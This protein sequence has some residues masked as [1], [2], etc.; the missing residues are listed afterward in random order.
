MALSPYRTGE[1]LVGLVAVWVFLD[2]MFPHLGLT[3]I[4][5]SA[6]RADERPSLSQMTRRH[7]TLE[8]ARAGELLVCVCVCKCACE[9]ERD[10][11]RERERE[12]EREVIQ[13]TKTYKFSWLF[14]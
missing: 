5:L 2:E 11:E 3:L 7:V 1:F 8:S 13:P 4:R 10:T 6:D 14:I 9:T 12:K